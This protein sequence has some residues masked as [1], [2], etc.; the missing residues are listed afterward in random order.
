EIF[1]HDPSGNGG[2]GT[3]LT[4]FDIPGGFR[5]RNPVSR[6]P[7]AHAEGFLDHFCRP[8]LNGLSTD[9]DPRHKLQQ[10]LATWTRSLSGF[11]FFICAQ[12]TGHDIR[13]TPIIYFYVKKFTIRGVI[14]KYP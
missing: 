9:I 6:G 1:R 11:E 8:I 7:R 4:R 13:H 14:E 12:P 2:L 5:F 3:V 10:L